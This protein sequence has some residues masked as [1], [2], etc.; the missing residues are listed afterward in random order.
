MDIS[1]KCVNISEMLLVKIDHRK[2]YENMEFDDFQANHRSIVQKRL[3]QFH[4]EIIHT[5][6]KTFEVFKG[7]GTEVCGAIFL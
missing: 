1:T 5:M 3:K 6:K 2:V 4:D 7:D